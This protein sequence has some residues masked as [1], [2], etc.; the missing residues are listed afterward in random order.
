VGHWWSTPPLLLNP[1]FDQNFVSCVL[2]NPT[3][4]PDY[5]RKL[6]AVYPP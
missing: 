3:H 5:K 1:F 4:F 6:T 2:N